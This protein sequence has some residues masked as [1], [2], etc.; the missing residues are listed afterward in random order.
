MR[1]PWA[2]RAVGQFVVAEATGIRSFTPGSRV[3][4]QRGGRWWTAVV[5]RGSSDGSYRVRYDD[6]GAGGDEDVPSAR[7][8]PAGAA[9]PGPRGTQSFEMLAAGLAAIAILGG[10]VGLAV[11]RDLDRTLD[12]PDDLA[13]RAVPE[14]SS[15]T[16][17]RIV[18]VRRDGAWHPAVVLGAGDDGTM[19][20]H[21]QDE[22]VDRDGAVPI[23]QIRLR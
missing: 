20:V 10:V 21:Y 18:W 15:L 2:K 22:I 11:A 7:V 16:R 4:A 14:T 12:V 8:A 9:P 13:E 1:V 23:D 17:E 6:W 19:R 3:W 5:L